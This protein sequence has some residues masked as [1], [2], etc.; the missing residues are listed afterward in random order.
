M[1][2]S[3][4]TTRSDGGKLKKLK[5]IYFSKRRLIVRGIICQSYI[6]A[7][8]RRGGLFAISKVHC[9]TTL[10]TGLAPQLLPS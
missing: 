3:S 4:I 1:P 5:S 8:Q 2:R 9:R 10:F 7:A 6:T